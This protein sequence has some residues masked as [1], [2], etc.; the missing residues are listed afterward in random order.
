MSIMRTPLMNDVIPDRDSFGTRLP[1]LPTLDSANPAGMSHQEAKF[2]EF[3]WAEESRKSLIDEF[4]ASP[5]AR[6]RTLSAADMEELFK[7]W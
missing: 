2:Q 5:R 3:Q 7:D 4:A 6:T 1:F